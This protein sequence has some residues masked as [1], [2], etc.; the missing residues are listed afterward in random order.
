VRSLLDA[1]D[2]DGAATLAIERYGPAVLKYLRLLLRDEHD[3]ADA[4]SLFEEH[5]WRGLAAFRAQSSLRTW[6]FRV[7]RNAATDTRKEE[8]RRRGRPLT[9]PVANELVEG[10]VDG[11]SDVS[12][13]REQFEPLRQYLSESEQT[14]LILRVE[15]ELPWREIARV[16]SGDGREL[17]TTTVMK[18]FNRLVARLRRMARQHGLLP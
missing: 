12:D 10:G 13:L 5:L 1:G 17:D 8:W 7:A 9:T 15:R 18:R 11:R 6:L 14:L 4:Y 2:L 16:L 3:A